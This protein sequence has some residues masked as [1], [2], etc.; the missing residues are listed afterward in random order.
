MQDRLYINEGE[1]K[2][3]KAINVLPEI[4]SSGSCVKSADYD[5]DGDLDLFVGGRIIPGKYPFPPQSYILNNQN[6]SFVDVTTNIAPELQFLGM[7]TDATWADIDNDGHKDIVAVGEWMPI[8]IFK[9]IN[10]TFIS[11]PY[12]EKPCPL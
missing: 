3:K 2:F 8:S 4:R 11:G 10:G 9:N 12:S 1:G 6:G 5:N 7:I